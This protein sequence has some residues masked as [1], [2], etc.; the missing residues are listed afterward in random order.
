MRVA[1][2][3]C[4]VIYAPPP[5]AQPNPPVQPNQPVQPVQQGQPAADPADGQQP[6]QA[7][8]VIEPVQQVEPSAQNQRF[9]PVIN[10]CIRDLVFA[11]INMGVANRPLIAWDR[12]NERFRFITILP[13]GTII[14]VVY[15]VDAPYNPNQ[16]RTRARSPPGY[17]FKFPN[18]DRV[19]KF[20]F[21]KYGSQDV[22]YIDESDAIANIKARMISLPGNEIMM[23][24]YTT[25]A[26]IDGEIVAFPSC[27]SHI[28]FDLDDYTD[29]D[30]EWFG[31]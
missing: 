20:N 27:E 31:K 26:V 22:D 19:S 23:L 30:G 11:H 6:A 25:R 12:L 2:R 29:E 7:V 18:S 4:T 10:D 9:W 21:G 5:P 8:R 13:E 24:V 3:C 14:K 28:D 15:G 1:I 17:K 16:R